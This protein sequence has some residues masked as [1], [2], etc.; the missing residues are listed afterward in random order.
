[1]EVV[2]TK[3]HSKCCDVSAT[4]RRRVREE[5]KEKAQGEKLGPRREKAHS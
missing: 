4:L 2:F 1:V 5:K 3:Y